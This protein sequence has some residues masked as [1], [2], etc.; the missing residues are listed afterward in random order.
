MLTFQA[1]RIHAIN[2]PIDGR[3]FSEDWVPDQLPR[4]AV[5]PLTAAGVRWHL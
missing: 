4:A 2:F 3:Y 1:L 5:G